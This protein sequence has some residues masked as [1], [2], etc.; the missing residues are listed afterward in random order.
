LVGPKINKNPE[1]ADR[2]ML[3][4]HGDWSMAVGPC[5]YESLKALLTS[6]EF[7]FEGIVWHHNDGRKTKIKRRDFA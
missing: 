4:R 6:D 3:L 5:D 2:H 7:T 1:G